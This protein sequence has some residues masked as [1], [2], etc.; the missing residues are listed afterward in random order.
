MRK[1][2]IYILIILSLFFQS[3]QCL[4][5]Q[6]VHY[7]QFFSAPFTIN[8]A[9]AG[10]FEGTNRL[11]SIYRQQWSN[12]G[13]PFT[14]ST[15]AFD[16]KA[17]SGDVYDQNPFNLGVQ[18]QSEKS[19][20]GAM[21]GNFITGV[22]SYHVPLNTEGTQSLGLGISGSYGKRRVDLSTLA[23][24][25]QFASGGFDLTLPSGEVALQNMK[26]FFSINTGLLYTYNNKEEGTFFDVGVGVFHANQPRQT[27]LYDKNDRVPMRLSAQ[28]NLQRYVAFDLVMDFRL[29]YQNQA[30]NDYLSG[31]ISLSKLLQEDA[32]GSVLGIGCWYRTDDAISPYV[33]TEINRFKIGFSY[34]IQ[35]NDI[36]KEAKPSSS[37]EF[38]LQWRFRKKGGY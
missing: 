15:L 35:I 10:V 5:A 31:G 27:F 33:F 19:L 1:S 8:P 29:L 4:F 37:I 28:L 24:A 22:S 11:T 20:K 18:F 16:T 3:L 34:D 6:D 25:S 23:S 26:S 12:L 2:Y 36:R 14:S 9:Y 32:D 7:T 30:E 17:F 21:I 38:S 13:T